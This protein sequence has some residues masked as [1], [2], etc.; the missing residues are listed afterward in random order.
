MGLA[1]AL[2][3]MVVL[4]RRR[5]SPR[6]V[7]APVEAT[8]APSP[9]SARERARERLARLRGRHPEGRAEIEAYYAEATALLRDYIGERFAVDASVLSTFEL[10]RFHRL[11]A[12]V[13]AHGDLVRF[14]CHEPTVPERQRML[15]GAAA[16]LEQTA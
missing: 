5:R 8:G 2:A 14:A 16:F 7:A 15:E 3:A 12:D 6:P 10:A 13:L 4:V 9:P 11:L 1:L